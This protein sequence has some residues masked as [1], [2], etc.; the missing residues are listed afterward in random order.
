M[1]ACVCGCTQVCT[2]AL[3]IHINTVWE[4]SRKEEV[5]THVHALSHRQ[6]SQTYFWGQ[7][8]A[9]GELRSSLR[10]RPW[11]LVLYYRVP[12]QESW[13]YA[14]GI[15]NWMVY[16]LCTAIM[17]YL[18]HCQFIEKNSLFSSHSE[19][20]VSLSSIGFFCDRAPSWHGVSKDQELRNKHLFFSLWSLFS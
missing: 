7:Y 20:H 2:C 18:K 15:F 1:C 17:K 5:I 13:V 6:C 9:K 12:K 10:S 8:S 11:R 19:V 3:C 4:T 16:K 14:L